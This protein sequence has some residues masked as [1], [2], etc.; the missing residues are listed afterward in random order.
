MHQLFPANK[1]LTENICIL[2]LEQN[3]IGYYFEFLCLQG[4]GWRRK[5]RSNISDRFQP[6]TLE[7]K[8]CVAQREV[9]ET[10]QDRE[11]L[12]LKS[13]KNKDNYKVTTHT[14]AKNK[15]QYI[16][17]LTSGTFIHETYLSFQASMKEAEL[18]LADVRKAKNDFERR[19]V[20]PT[21]DNTLEMKE[22]EKVLQYIEDKLKVTKLVFLTKQ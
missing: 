3:I 5:S 2:F 11:K 1:C 18:R 14:H 10:Q 9:R 19:L 4:V 22:P 12:K 7:Q 15:T 16:E 13:E 6:L 20:K 8:L 21:K 17:T